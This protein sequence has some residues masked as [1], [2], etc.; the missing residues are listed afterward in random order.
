MVLWTFWIAAQQ[1]TP[2]SLERWNHLHQGD[3]NLHWVKGTLAQLHVLDVPVDTSHAQICPIFLSTYQCPLATK[4]Q[5]LI[6]TFLLKSWLTTRIHVLYFSSLNG[7]LT[8]TENVLRLQD[9]Q[10]VHIADLMLTF[11]WRSLG[12]FD[13]CLWMLVVRTCTFRWSHA[14]HSLSVNR[15]RGP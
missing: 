2:F 10:V 8:Q 9:N 12:K 15:M 7:S 5:P 6:N 1:F 11:L 14:R 4:F 13:H 3:L